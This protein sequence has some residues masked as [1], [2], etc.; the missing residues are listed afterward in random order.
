M[1]EFTEAVKLAVA[2]L[3]A[4]EQSCQKAKD[5]LSAVRAHNGQGG[6]SVTVNGVSVAVSTCDSKTYQGTLIRG[7]EMIHLG[8]LKALGAELQAAEDRVR[9][10]RKMLSELVL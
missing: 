2:K 9:E 5:R 3:E 10:C 7:R 6:Y 1:S 8:A 4:A